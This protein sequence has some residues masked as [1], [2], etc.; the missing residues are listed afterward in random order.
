M[1]LQRLPRAPHQHSA[2]PLNRPQTPQLSKHGYFG[3]LKRPPII[4]E[5]L[6]KPVEFILR[7][8]FD[9]ALTAR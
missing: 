3:V 8:L 6:E 1:S 4:L 7:E 5:Q 2:F 9:Q